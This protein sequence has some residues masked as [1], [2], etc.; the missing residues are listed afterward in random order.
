MIIPSID[1]MNGKSVQLIQGQKKVLER[2]NPLTLAKE[3]R[4]YGDIAVIDLDA[5]LGKGNNKELIKKICKIADCRVGG[6]IR[7]QEIANEYLQA[8]AK[9]III[10]TKANTK[11]LS[12]L[13]KERLLVALDSKKGKVVTQGW[14]N[15]TENNPIDV[16]QNT[17]KFCSGYLFTDVDNEGLMQGFNIN[18][19]K[20]IIKSTNKKITVAGSISSSDEIKALESLG[21]DSQIGMAL[22]TGKIKLDETF[23]NQLDF[24]KT[25]SLIPTIVQ[26]EQNQ[27]LM[28]AFSNKESLKETFKTNNATYYSRTKKRLWMKG[29]TSNNTQEI[30]KVRYDCDKDTLIFTVKQKN[31]ACHQGEY[32]CF[33]EK[34]FNIEDLFEVI[35]SRVD[36]PKVDSFTSKLAEDEKNIMKKIKEESDEVI[37]YKD[38]QNL[39]W[40]IADLQYFLFVLMAKKSI[41]PQDIK[42]ELWRRR[43]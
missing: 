43:K 41:T 27:I 42:N 32:S 29:E 21:I 9:K 3:F 37:N 13:P 39:I 16:I 5:A 12:Q 2:E 23:I 36:S 35:K 18:T 11:F 20:E 28:L 25:N 6:G 15:K 8:G 10:G 17:E 1:I 24:I 31:I 22:Y 26:D 14:K 38:K 34:E 4:K 19:I 40:E 7:T 33:G 30:L